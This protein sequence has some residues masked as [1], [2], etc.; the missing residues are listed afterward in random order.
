MSWRD[1]GV[2]AGGG[3]TDGGSTR[4]PAE[5]T[6]L[7]STSECALA[8]TVPTELLADRVRPED[9]VVVVTTREA[10]AAVA[11]R[12]EST[13]D[14]LTAGAL[15]VVSSGT[16]GEGPSETAGV[17]QVGSAPDPGALAAAVEAAYDDLAGGRV[18]LLV[19]ALAA[20]AYGSVEPVYR[21][22]HEVAMAV[23]AEPGL[24][25]FAVDAGGLPASFV[26]RLAH[27]VDVHLCLREQAGQPEACWTS[28]TGTSDGWRPWADVE[29]AQV[30]RV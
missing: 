27:L 15:S 1:G 10:P 20:P 26:D 16:E 6:V 5:P 23:G 19:D 24:G 30:H 7:L 28:L 17:R 22:A 11:G 8:R 4:R 14:A 18:H 21:R 29:F 25:L 9:G 3:R 12:L 2:E 13:V